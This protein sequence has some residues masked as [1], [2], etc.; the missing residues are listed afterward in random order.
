M[1]PNSNPNQNPNPNLNPSFNPVPNPN[2]MRPLAQSGVREMPQKKSHLAV[3]LI[4]VLVILLAFGF[5]GWK[6]FANQQAMEALQAQNASMQAD[7]ANTP[8]SGDATNAGTDQA[9]VSRSMQ[10]DAALDSDMSF[11]LD[12]SSENDLKSIDQEY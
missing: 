4:L 3:T 10:N 5:L 9:S 2:P 1:N 7:V 11:V 12:S 6:W 8:A